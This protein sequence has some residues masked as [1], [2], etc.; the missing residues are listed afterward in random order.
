MT[1]CEATHFKKYKA[2]IKKGNVRP[3]EAWDLHQNAEERPCTERVDGSLMTLRR[4]C[5]AIYVPSLQKFLTPRQL[6]RMMGWP[7][8]KEDCEA[9]SLPRHVEM[10]D[11]VSDGQLCSMAGNGMFGPCSALTILAAMLWVERI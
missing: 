1:S 4:N 8:L 2:E 10:P 5:G 11:S 9:L 7:M 3:S 6:M